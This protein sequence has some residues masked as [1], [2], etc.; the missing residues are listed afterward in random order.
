MMALS[1]SWAYFASQLQISH[2]LRLVAQNG[3]IQCHAMVTHCH[4]FL[5]QNLGFI[6]T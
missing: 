4:A 2:E 6:C 3:L 1:E 5:A